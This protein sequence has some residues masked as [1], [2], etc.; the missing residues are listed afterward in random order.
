MKSVSDGSITFLTKEKWDRQGAYTVTLNFYSCRASSG[1]RNS[2][3]DVVRL[4]SAE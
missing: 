2:S 1:G 3:C 4:A